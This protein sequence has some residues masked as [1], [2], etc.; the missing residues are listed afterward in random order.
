MRRKTA[1][2]AVLPF[3]F[4]MTV[5]AA[6]SANAAPIEECNDSKTATNPSQSGGD[7]WVCTNGG[8]NAGN[9]ERT[10]NPNTKKW[11]DTPN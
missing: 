3:V 1:G 8:G 6:P 7:G 9:D 5:M 2:L 4:G 11:G 10:K